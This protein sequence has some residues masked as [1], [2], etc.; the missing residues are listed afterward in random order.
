MNGWDDLPA[1]FGRSLRL[2]RW[3]GPAGVSGGSLVVSSPGGVG[4]CW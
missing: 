4:M 3:R 2:L 1:L